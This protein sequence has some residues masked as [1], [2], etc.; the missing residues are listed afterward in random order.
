MTSA[1]NWSYTTT[2]TIWKKGAKNEYNE[3]EYAAPVTISCDYGFVSGNTQGAVI[4]AIGREVIVKNTF[5][6]EYAD[7]VAGDY[8][9]LGISTLA[10]P[11]EAEADEIIVVTNYGNTLSREELPDF[12]LVTG[13]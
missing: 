12:M 8:I 10:S 11:I 1:A 5:W 6:T 13:K 4:A 2:A 3:F 9:L 7:T